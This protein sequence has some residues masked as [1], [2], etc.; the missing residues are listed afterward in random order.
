MTFHLSLVHLATLKRVSI[1]ACSKAKAMLC[2]AKAVGEA[3]R[4]R[5]ANH[6]KLDMRLRV[7]LDQA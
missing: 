6:P 5:K 4:G 2:K 3:R 1:A 7:S